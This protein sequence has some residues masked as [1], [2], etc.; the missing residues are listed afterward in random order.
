MPIA[1]RINKTWIA[2]D[3]M[4]LRRNFAR[5]VKKIIIVNIDSASVL[6]FM[7]GSA[8]IIT[9]NNIVFY[10]WVFGLRSSPKLQRK[11]SAIANSSV[12]NANVVVKRTV[13]RAIHG[14]YLNRFLFY[15]RL[16]P[17]IIN[18]YNVV[19]CQGIICF[20]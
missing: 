18:N 1:L 4:N 11:R 12:K 16:T 20:C 5:A 8:F 13:F 6:Q 17:S 2:I 7:L 19:I 14:I 9:K 10:F 3:G 15:G